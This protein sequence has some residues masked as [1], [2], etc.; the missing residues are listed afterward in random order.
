[1]GRPGDKSSLA[2]KNTLRINYAQN[3]YRR[4]AFGGPD[5]RNRDFDLWR[6]WRGP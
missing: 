4:V 6:D 1:M 3:I 2:P 5:G